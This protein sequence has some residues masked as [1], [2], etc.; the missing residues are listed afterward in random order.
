[1]RLCCHGPIDSVIWRAIFW[2]RNTEAAL[3]IGALRLMLTRK[4]GLLTLPFTKRDRQVMQ[5]LRYPLCRLMAMVAFGLVT[6]IHAQATDDS[7]PLKNWPAPLAWQ[8]TTTQEVSVEHEAQHFRPLMTEP[9][10]AA[11]LT[12]L[13]AI[14][15]CRLVD[16]RQNWAAPYG[17]GAWSKGSTSTLN[18]ASSASGQCSLPAAL[19]YSANITVLMSYGGTLGFVTVYPAGT[20][21]PSTSALNNNAG[22]SIVNSSAVI[23]AGS[24][25]N[26]GSF[27]VYLSPNGTASLVNVIIDINGYYISPSGLALGTGTAATPSLTF[28]NDVSTGLYSSAPST[29]NIST[30]GTNRVTVLPNGNVG[31]GTPTPSYLLDVAG[32]IN[33]TGILRYQNS[34]ILR[35][36]PSSPNLGLGSLALQNNTMGT[37]N[38]AVGYNTLFGNTS[39][40]YNTAFGSSAS[41]SN[42]GGSYNTAVGSS[43]LFNSTGSTNTAIGYSAL[44]NNMA[45]SN[46]IALGYNAAE[47]VAGG[48]SNNIHIG[49]KGSSGDSGTIRIGGNTALGD[50]AGQ[51]S[52]FAAGV[53]GVQTGLNNAVPVMVD[54]NGQLGTVNSSRRFKEDIQ[55]MGD[56]SSGLMRLRP[57]T[58]RYRKPFADG[59]KPL[60][61]GLIAEEVGQVYPDLVVHSA[62]GQVQTVKY[63]VLDSMLL[64]EVKRQRTEITAQKDHIRDLQEQIDELKT[65]LALLEQR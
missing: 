25:A 15:P 19:A 41:S 48:N 17:G 34:P 22:L 56:A 49:T 26:A 12:T 61:Y 43:S 42:T 33:L 27:N 7:V 18:G 59:S 10:G 31:I 11:Q 23:P 37:S 53:N 64:N 5:N 40:S 46:N 58:F 62:D 6:G 21:M 20:S 30:S 45:G 55:D 32:D 44:G 8:P 1:M 65:V 29:I 47:A 38:T 4:F 13:V 60:Q 51:T 28:S 39:G 3:L 52:F 2:C 63:Q 35:F 16:T 24:G 50:P 54:G 14:T 57:V 9:G 36:Q